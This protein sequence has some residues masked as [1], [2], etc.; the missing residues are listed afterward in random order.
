MLTNDIKE[1]RKTGIGGSDVAAIAGKSKWATPLDIYLEKIGEKERNKNEEEPQNGPKYWGKVLEEVVA[2]E[3]TKQTGKSLIKKVGIESMFRHPEHHHMIANLDY[4]ID[5]GKGILECKTASA[6]IRKEWG[7]EG[8]DNMPEAYLMQ[9]AH[10]SKVLEKHGIEYVDS[11]VLIGGNDYKIYRYTKSH[12][13]EDKIVKLE[14]NF[15]HQHVVKKT[16]PKTV[17]IADVLSLFPKGVGGDSKTATQDVINTINFL[18][19]TRTSIQALEEK[20][21]LYKKQVCESIADAEVLVDPA[22]MR[23]ATWKNQ[24]AARFDTMSFKKEYSDL[25]KEFCKTTETRVLRIA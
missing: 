16:P 25:Y 17:N 2:K 14:H 3:Y 21:A 10:Y 24:E 20:E 4:L 11:P 6:F 15:W 18:K 13:L 9:C 5:D 1:A 22:G 12:E 7:E 8:T 23:L 19:E